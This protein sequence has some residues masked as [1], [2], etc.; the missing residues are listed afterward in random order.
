MKKV[1]YAVVAAIVALIL[2]ASVFM[3]G[4]MYVVRNAQIW[5]E[6]DQMCIDVFDQVWVYDYYSGD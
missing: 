2:A 3:A 1:C 4:A 6:G 5:V